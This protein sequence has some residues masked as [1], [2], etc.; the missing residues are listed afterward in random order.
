MT[1]YRKIP[2]AIAALLDTSIVM[3]AEISM[4]KCEEWHPR[5]GQVADKSFAMDLTAKTCNGQPCAISQAQFKWSEGN[6]RY[7]FTFDRASGEG[8]RFYTGEL[9]F[10][11]KNCKLSPAGT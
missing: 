7:E 10:S 2:W 6:G 11:Y 3:G 9:V 4:L 8:T 5:L 1:G